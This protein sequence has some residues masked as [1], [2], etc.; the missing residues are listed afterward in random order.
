MSIFN[1]SLSL[2]LVTGWRAGAAMAAAAGGGPAHAP[3]AD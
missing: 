3:G 1:P 2:D